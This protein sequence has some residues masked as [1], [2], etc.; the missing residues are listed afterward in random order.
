[1]TLLRKLLVLPLYLAAG[2]ADPL[3][4]RLGIFAEYVSDWVV[5]A[6]SD[7]SCFRRR[8]VRWAVHGTNSLE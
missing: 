5:Y 8:L 7:A 2:V 4:Y 3:L 1:M 6:R